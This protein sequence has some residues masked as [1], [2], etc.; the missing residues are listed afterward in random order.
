MVQ[1]HLE[2]QNTLVIIIQENRDPSLPGPQTVLR[3]DIVQMLSHIGITMFNLNIPVQELLLSPEFFFFF[4]TEAEL[5][6][7]GENEYSMLQVTR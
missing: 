4:L 6:S 3:I 7:T 5:E 1:C 2:W